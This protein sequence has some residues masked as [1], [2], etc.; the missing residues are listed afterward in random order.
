MLSFLLDSDTNLATARNFVGLNIG[1]SILA[2][3][4]GRR[5]VISVEISR[6]AYAA[7]SYAMCM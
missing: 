7:E 2:V 4:C 1:L 5:D 6:M 3:Q